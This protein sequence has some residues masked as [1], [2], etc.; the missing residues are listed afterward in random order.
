MEMFTVI[1]T[2]IKAMAVV[3]P[4]FGMLVFAGWILFAIFIAKNGK[5]LVARFLNGPQKK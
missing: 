2:I 4:L 5:K 1:L 3:I